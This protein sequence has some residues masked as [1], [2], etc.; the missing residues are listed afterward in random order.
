MILDRSAL[1][2]NYHAHPPLTNAVAASMRA[3]AAAS[4]PAVRAM[5]SCASAWYQHLIYAPGRVLAP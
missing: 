2:K 1:R 3:L 4:T 5:K